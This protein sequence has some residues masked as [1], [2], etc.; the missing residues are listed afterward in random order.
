MLYNIRLRTMKNP[1]QH[2]RPAPMTEMIDLY[3]EK[4]VEVTRLIALD[5]GKRD[6]S[7][8]VIQVV[9]HLRSISFRE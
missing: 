7:C 8:Q 6:F 4:W 1:N 3:L 9:T 2:Y 5:C